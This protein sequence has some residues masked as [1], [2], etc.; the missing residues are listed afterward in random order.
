LYGISFSHLDTLA[1]IYGKDIVTGEG[2]EG[3]GDA[4]SNWRKK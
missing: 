4:I 3:L 2:V 1:A